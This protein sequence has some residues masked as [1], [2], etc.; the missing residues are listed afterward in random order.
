MFC[1]VHI[2][3]FLPLP[4]PS[5]ILVYLEFW[6]PSSVCTCIYFTRNEVGFPPLLRRVSLSYRYGLNGEIHVLRI[7][8]LYGRVA[9]PLLDFTERGLGTRLVTPLSLSS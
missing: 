5:F 7:K 9:R 8:A 2:V 1:L 4:S 6:G 3:Q